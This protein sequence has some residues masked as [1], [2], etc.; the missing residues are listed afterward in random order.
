MTDVQ[1]L[2]LQAMASRL[3]ISPEGESSQEFSG[4][5]F[6]FRDEGWVLSWRVPVHPRF[7]T[8]PPATIRSGR[9]R[10]S[11]T[12]PTPKSRQDY[13]GMGA[14]SKSLGAA[15]SKELRRLAIGPRRE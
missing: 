6:D 3:Y 12:P 2:L 1:F 14:S 10:T 15:L 13:L 8:R 4:N 7:K 5:P 11:A 9:A